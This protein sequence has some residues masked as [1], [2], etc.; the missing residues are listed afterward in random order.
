MRRYRHEIDNVRSHLRSLWIVIGLEIG[1]ILVLGIALLRAPDGIVVHIPPDLRSGAAVKPDS[2]S[3]A[4]VYSFAFYIFQQLNR[5]PENGSEDYG[6]AIFSLAAYLTPKYQAELKK[7]LDL[8]GR[9][10]ELINR[11]RG[12]QQ[13]VGHGYSEMRV[14]VLSDG[15]WIVWVDM[16]LHESVKGM[17]IKKT[18]IRYPLRVVRY[19]VD[20]ESNPWR[21]ALDGFGQE[22]PRRLEAHEL[23]TA[24]QTSDKGETI[25]N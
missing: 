12:M 3:P 4:N 10:G 5:W 21:L 13:R 24:T 20:P 25:A 22:G 16:E 17:K 1:V 11:V 14:D 15:V 23:E 9:R 6:K 8:K 18:F 2:P 19:A 7:E